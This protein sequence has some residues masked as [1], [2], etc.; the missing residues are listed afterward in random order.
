VKRHQ[1]VPNPTEIHDF[2]LLGI[3][4]Y[5][6]PIDNNLYQGAGYAMPV[7]HTQDKAQEVTVG[8]QGPNTKGRQ[9]C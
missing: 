9:V 2:R 3:V 4:T 7:G 5:L 1:L 8:G 6:S